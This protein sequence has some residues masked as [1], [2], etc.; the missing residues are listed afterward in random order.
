VGDGKAV[1]LLFSKKEE[2]GA[3]SKG[4][5]GDKIKKKYGN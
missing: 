1:L 5:K 4:L 2:F 3:L